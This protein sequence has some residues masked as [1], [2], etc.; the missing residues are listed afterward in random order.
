MNSLEYN[1]GDHSKRNFA[2]RGEMKSKFAGAETL[3]INLLGDEMRKD[4]MCSKHSFV[5]FNLQKYAATTAEIFL[6]IS[7]DNGDELQISSKKLKKNP[8][9]AKK[10]DFF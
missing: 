2:L 7:A 6:R 9:L 10:I 3:K 1:K 4:L 8:F 5:L